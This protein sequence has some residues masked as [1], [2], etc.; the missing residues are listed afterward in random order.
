MAVN[1]EEA[2]GL[3]GRGD[4]TIIKKLVPKS[5]ES[6]SQLCG[7][8]SDVGARTTAPTLQ[9]ITGVCL[10]SRCQFH[11]SFRGSWEDPRMDRSQST[12]NRLLYSKRSHRGRRYYCWRAVTS[13][14]M[15]IERRA[16]VHR[17]PADLTLGGLGGPDAPPEFAC[18]LEELMG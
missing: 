14:M 11:S 7:L 17:G 1:L 10:A 5:E 18:H 3:R 13:V 16:G 8:L 2:W 6:E 9:V 4:M 15:P 12:K